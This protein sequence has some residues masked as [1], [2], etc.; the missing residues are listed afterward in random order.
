MYLH[1]IGEFVL[2]QIFRF[3]VYE[4]TPLPYTC[5]LKYVSQTM[6]VR[7]ELGLIAIGPLF[8]GFCF[9]IFF[10]TSLMY[11]REYLFAL[12]VRERHDIKVGRERGVKYCRR[13]S[14]FH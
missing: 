5:V 6:P 12:L 3:P 4:F 14:D 1:Y 2:L 9:A 11:Q 10:A 8:N 13:C 7:Y